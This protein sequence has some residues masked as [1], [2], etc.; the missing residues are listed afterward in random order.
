MIQ[1]FTG[2]MMGGAPVPA[3]GKDY[4]LFVMAIDPQIFLDKADFDASVLAFV[5][6]IKSSKRS[7]GVAEILIPGERAY[8]ERA[9]RQVE[10]LEIDDDVMARIQQL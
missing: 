10:G 1:M 9:L 3:P 6:K 4:G 7:E 2:V 8:R 5:S